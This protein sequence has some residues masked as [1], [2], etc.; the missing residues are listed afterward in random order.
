MNKWSNYQLLKEPKAI[1]EGKYFC[2]W[3]THGSTYDCLTLQWCESCYAFSKNYTL[4]L[5]F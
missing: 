5:E 4:S 3:L 1:P 2:L